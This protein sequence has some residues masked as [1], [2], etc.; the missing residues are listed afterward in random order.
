MKNKNSKTEID[1]S[2]LTPK[3]QIGKVNHSKNYKKAFLKNNTESKSNFS[4]NTSADD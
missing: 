2:N 4:R 3:M 1:F